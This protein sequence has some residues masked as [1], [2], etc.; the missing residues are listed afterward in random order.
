MDNDQE[1]IRHSVAL[2]AQRIA[3]QNKCVDLSIHVTSGLAVAVAGSVF[4]WIFNIVNPGGLVN[5]LTISVVTAIILGFYVFIQLLLLTNYIYHTVAIYCFDCAYGRITW[6]SSRKDIPSAILNNS[7]NRLFKAFPWVVNNVQPLALYVSIGIGWLL[8]VLI[9]EYSLV[10]TQPSTIWVL[11]F[12]GCRILGILYLIVL[13][14]FVWVHC[15]ARLFA[16]HNMWLRENIWRA[17]GN[18]ADK[19]FD[20][21]RWI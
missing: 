21:D 20:V 9:V 13:C 10:A 18:G 1:S 6:Q 11:F 7:E 4:A 8:F 14:F 15:H 16:E 17:S 19:D 2:T 12:L 5:P 3:L